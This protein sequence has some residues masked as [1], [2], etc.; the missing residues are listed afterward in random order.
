M[1]FIFI[2]KSAR[3]VSAGW[4]GANFVRVTLMAAVLGLV[5]LG[6]GKQAATESPTELIEQSFQQATPETKEAIQNVVASLK[7]KEFLAAARSLVTVLDK[8]SFTPEQ[9]HAVGAVLNQINE[10]IAADPKLNSQEMFTLR[11]KIF[12]ALNT[13]SDV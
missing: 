13:H 1:R 4:A 9:K 12:Q 8:D 5:V 2:N 11:E 10:A 3:I 7:A 6:C